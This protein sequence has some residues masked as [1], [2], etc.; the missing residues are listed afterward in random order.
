[1]MA[2]GDDIHPLFYGGLAAFYA[3]YNLSILFKLHFTEAAVPI[4][5]FKPYVITEVRYVYPLL[6]KRLKDGKPA[7]YLG[8]LS[9]YSYLYSFKF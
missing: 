7:I 5:P 8:F 6:L 3:S 1:M 9:V 4:G 2:G